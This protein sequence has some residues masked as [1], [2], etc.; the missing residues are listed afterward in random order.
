MSGA[1]VAIAH[2]GLIA[3]LEQAADGIVITDAAGTI[4][5]VN[6]AFTTLTGYS[7]EEAVG[8]NPRLLK[9]DRHDP[10]FYQELWSTLLSGKIWQGEITNRHKDGSLY[11]EEMRIAP[12]LDAAGATT[13]YIAIKHDVTEQRAHESA[14]AFLAAIVE[15]SEDAI[16]AVAPA[17]ATATMASSECSTMAARK[18][19]ADSWA[20]CSVT[21]C[22]MAI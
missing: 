16:V 19:W 9:S 13:G 21:S 6:P 22:L 18:A 5:Y 3:A 12:V 20:R 17:G 1:G 14:Q 8:G 2:A 10:A 7:R 15:H 4:Q 11:D